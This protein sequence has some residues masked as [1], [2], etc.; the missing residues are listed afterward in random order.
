MRIDSPRRRADEEVCVAEEADVDEDLAAARSVLYR[1]GLAVAHRRRLVLGAAVLAVVVGCVAY[2]YLH[3]QLTGLDWEADDSESARVSAFVQEHFDGLGSEQAAIVFT[4]P[5]HQ[6]AAARSAVNHIVAAARSAEGVAGVVGPFD[7]GTIGQVSA[8]RQVA[9]AAVGLTGDPSSRSDYAARL[10]KVVAEIASGSDVEARLTGLSPILNDEITIEERSA[11]KGETLGVVLALI[12][13]ILALGSVVAACVPLVV[14]LVS[15]SITFAALALAS[16]VLPFTSFIISCVTMIGTGLAIDYSLFIVSR[17]REQLALEQRGG[18][19]RE[20]ATAVSVA[21]AVATSGRTIVVAGVIVAL[22]MCSLFFLK[23]SIFREVAIA[24]GIAVA[25]TLLSALTVLPAVLGI[26]GPKI[27]RLGLPQRWLPAELQV[28]QYSQKAT[29]WERWARWVMRRPVVAG[30]VAALILIAAAWPLGSLRYGLDYGLSA[31]GGTPSGQ[32]A[33][34]L[35]EAFTPG[36][37]APIQIAASGRG[38]QPL[39]EA[40]TEQ[41]EVFAA[42]V[43]GG[44]DVAN[45]NLQRQG[46]YMLVTVVPSAAV[47]SPATTSLVQ[48]IRSDSY[49]MVGSGGPQLR[50]GG[51]TASFIDLD[52]VTSTGTLPVLGLV[53]GVSLLYLLGVFRS[54]ALAFKAVVMNLLT[55]AAAVGLTVAIF[56]WGWLSSVL[57]FTS[58]GFLQFYMP[59]VVFAVIFGLSMDYQVFLLRRIREEWLITGDNIQAVV[60]GLTR[61]ARPITAAA[62]IMVCVFGSFV[63]SQVLEMKQ[64]GFGLAAAVALDAILV[65]MALVPALMRVLG[66]WNWWFPSFLVNLTPQPP[67][68]R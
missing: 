29:G 33:A 46:G 12:V 48:R 28:D 19:T 53:V 15:L 52:R 27:D 23:A 7:R 37:L 39:G 58:V 8:D 6:V 57:G 63:T 9:F 18:A 60:A 14:T 5:G 56:Q 62:A 45:V 30:S 49:R 17:F 4:V 61:T 50:V 22:A 11:A 34:I 64:L 65:R 20:Q 2:P 51:A 59:A 24:I 38:G 66:R 21:T 68:G 25:C 67:G 36:A 54:V 3:S 1:W 13:L 35:S 31:L 41:V 32:G 16:L 26:L 44:P 42:T 10:Q 47:D 40:Q 43:A 55:T